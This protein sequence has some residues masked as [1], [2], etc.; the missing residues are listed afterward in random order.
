[1][2][3]SDLIRYEKY[4]PGWLTVVINIRTKICD[5]SAKDK[6]SQIRGKIKGEKKDYLKEKLRRSMLSGALA[7]A[8]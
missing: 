7:L 8:G 2:G 6:M 5:F 1:M 3:C 4:S